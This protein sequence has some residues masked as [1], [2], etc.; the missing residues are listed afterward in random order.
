MIIKENEMMPKALVRGILLVIAIISLITG[1]LIIVEGVN[2]N[3]DEKEAVLSYS[4]AGNINYMI[5]LKENN[6]Y[7]TNYGMYENVISKYIDT[8]DLI[9]RYNFSS[10]KQINT[11]GVYKANLYLINEYVEGNER[12][13]IS[14]KEFNL[15]PRTEQARFNSDSQIF[16]EKIT[17]DYNY[18]N[19]LARKWRE[20]SGLLTSSYL[21][22]E[23]TIQNTINT[24]D[25]KTEHDDHSVTMI[26]PLLENVVSMENANHF[27]DTKTLYNV[28][29]FSVNYIKLIIGIVLVLLSLAYTYTAIKIFLDVNNLSRYLKE[30]KQILKRYGDIIAETSTK[31]E[32]KNK[33]IIEITNLTDLVNIEDELRIPIIFYE[34]IPNKESWFIINH[35]DK[36]YKYTL[37]KKINKKKIK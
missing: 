37:K 10:T 31:P 35:N 15:L 5:T 24:L 7:D 33:D 17:I 13:I 8:I 16:N 25:E 3:K 32:L 22:V 26:I 19:E 29:K 20:E 9:F 2:G 21:K 18:Y 4:T 14:Q 36:V 30:Q 12:E 6:L 23:F 11:T 28:E 34:A 1:L 27:D